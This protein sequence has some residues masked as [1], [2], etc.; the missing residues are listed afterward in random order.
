MQT[1]P[2]YSPEVFQDI[3]LP[4]LARRWQSV[5]EKLKK[6]NYEAK[7]MLHSC[8]SIVDYIPDLIESGIEILDPLQPLATGMDPGLLYDSFGGE[9]VFH[10]GIDIQ[11]LLPNGTPEDIGEVTGQVMT[12][13]HAEQGGVII[14]P[15]HAIQA[16]VPPANIVA[17]VEC[18]KN[19]SFP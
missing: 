3:L 7:V 16:D 17:M 2:L 13:L 9:I 19:F 18:V 6:I 12:S 11:E 10:G 15:S 5:S 1:G 14:A 4:P 8:G